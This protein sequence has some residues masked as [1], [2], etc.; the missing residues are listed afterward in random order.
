MNLD[1]SL[2]AQHASELWQGF[3]LTCLLAVLVILGS[4]VIGL[5]VA[6]ARETGPRGFRLF[7]ATYSNI[8]RAT[9]VLVVLYFTFYGLPQVAFALDPIE[10]ALLGLTVASSAYLAEDM[11]AGIR[12]VDP[13]QWIASRAL[14]LPVG[15]TLRRIIL[16]QAFRIML[17]PCMTRYI[18]IVK[19][20]AVA[21]IVAVSE[22]TG[23][24]YALVSVT[25]RAFEFLGVAAVVYL[26]LNALL[27]F[28]Q[29][30]I[31][32]A[33]ARRPT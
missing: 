18:I 30:L 8:F 27:A 10:A 5:A 2:I 7:A 1:F 26:V 32:R 9:P 28:A 14:G 19:A 31:E 13:G 16:P 12:A 11:R 4:S 25:Y 23:R 33:M 20:T 29:A 24:A 6:L 15:W 21:S 22:L 3:L 17:A